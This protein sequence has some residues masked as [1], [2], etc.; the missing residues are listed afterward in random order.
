MS[1]N[2]VLEMSSKRIRDIMYQERHNLIL[3]HEYLCQ[4]VTLLNTFVCTKR[5]VQSTPHENN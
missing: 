5:E 4:C 1:V 3:G 2:I